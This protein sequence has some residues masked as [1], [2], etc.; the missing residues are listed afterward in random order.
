MPILPRAFITAVAVLLAAGAETAAPLPPFDVEKA[1]QAALL[2]DPEAATRAYLDAVPADRR[3]KT[4]AYA[5]GDYLLDL[6]GSLLNGLVLAGL[7]A[8]GAGARMR[9]RVQRLT[10]FRAIQAAAAWTVLLTLVSL[11]A[12]PL[13]LYRSYYREKAYGLLTQGLGDWTMDRV[14]MLAVGCVLGSLLVAALYGVM[15]RAPRTWWLWAAAVFVSFRILTNALFP[16]FIA[17]LFYNFT[18]VQDPQIRKDILVMARQHGVPGDDVYQVDASR[19]TDR[20]SAGVVGMLGTTRIAVFDTTLRRCNPAEVG[21]V[22]GHEIGHYVLNHL[23][24]ELAFSGA[25][26][27]LGFFFVR[28]AFD[29]AARRWPR[30]GVRGVADLAGLPLLWLLLGTWVFAVSPLRYTWL[31]ELETRADAFGLA[32]SRDP[33]AAATVFLKLGEYRDLEPHP[34]VEFLLF[35]HPSGKTRIRHAMEWKSSRRDISP[36]SPPPR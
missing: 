11:V 28:W 35:S 4:K 21:M 8:S 24:L 31:R 1:R 9:D 30:M 16:V 26:I 2:E 7:L 36:P 5:G 18:P 34:V 17:P 6:A 19:R 22:M 29:R 10:R 25:S 15:R 27:V 12:F 33:D 32:A 23:W 14:K 13:T 3:A 20:I